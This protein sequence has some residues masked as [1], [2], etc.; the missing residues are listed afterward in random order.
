MVLD[1][2]FMKRTLRACRS[3]MNKN[4]LGHRFH[5]HG[6]SSALIVFPYSLLFSGDGYGEEKHAMHVA[7]Y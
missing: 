1:S 4:P 5:K 2:V 6:D 7:T 3:G